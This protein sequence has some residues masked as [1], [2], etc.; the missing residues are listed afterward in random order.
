[1]KRSLLL[2]LIWLLLVSIMAT[3]CS[4]Q[5]TKVRVAT[6]ATYPPFTY[7]DEQTGQIVGFDIDL[8]KAIAQK[9][10]LEIEFVDVAFKP[11][12]EDMAQGKYD[13][14]ISA[15]SITEGRKKDMLFSDP[16]FVA[17][18]VVT[19][20]K[21]NTSITG[22]DNLVGKVIGVEIGSTSADS[23]SEMAG[24]TIKDY[25]DYGS[26]FNDLMNGVVDAVVSDNTIAVNYVTENPDKLRIAGEPFTQEYYGIAVAKN[27]AEL[28]ARINAGLKAVK[29]EGLIEKLTQKWLPK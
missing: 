7:I 28:L 10:N 11:L 29:R 24:V 27:K 4:Q 9:E 20:R 19:V 2:V 13:T 3:S 26:A 23:V 8:I 22:K 21:D 6:N 16:Y 5:A 17:G 14:A 15:I 18:H 1:M 25:V 12:L